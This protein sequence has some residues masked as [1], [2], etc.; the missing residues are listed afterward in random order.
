MIKKYVAIVYTELWVNLIFTDMFAWK[1]I[2]H[3]LL[4]PRVCHKSIFIHVNVGYLSAF[5]ATIPINTANSWLFVLMKCNINADNPKPLCFGHTIPSAARR[6]HLDALADTSNSSLSSEIQHLP[7]KLAVLSGSHHLPVY[8][9]R[10]LLQSCIRAE[11][12]WLLEH[13]H[14]LLSYVAHCP[15]LGPARHLTLYLSL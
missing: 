7:P 9:I 13:S 6:L 4:C 8:C 3:L 14:T 2:S 15:Q 1:W 12:T 5:L 11:C 10:N